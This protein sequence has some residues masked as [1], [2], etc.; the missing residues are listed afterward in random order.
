MKNQRLKILSFS[1]IAIF[2]VVIIK[3][4]YYQ[5]IAG[6]SLK[7]KNMA[8][9]YKIQ[10][11]S[12]NRGN[13][14]D[15]SNFPLATNNNWYQLSIYKPNLK[16][17]LIDVLN[18][19]DTK[20]TDFI[21]NNQNVIDIFS[22]NENQLWYTFPTQF[23]KEEKDALDID[24][25]SFETVQDRFYPEGN[26]GKTVIKGLENYYDKQL[27]GK[28]GFILAPKDAIGN[29]L[30]TQKTWQINSKNGIDLKTSLKRNIQYYT[31]QI[32]KKGL[33]QFS[34]D[35]GS[36]IIMDS[37]T[38]GI[39]AMST[40]EASPSGKNI[41][42]SDLFE[43]GS[44]FKPLVMSMA[45]DS[46]S[47]KPDYICPKCAGPL[48]IGE[49][50]ITN[51]D[52]K[53]HPNT[54]LKDII[55]NSDNVGMSN[56][57]EQLGQKKFQEYFEKLGLTQKTGIDLQGEAKPLI[58][59][60]YSKID[61]ATAAFGQGIAIS[62]IEFL[63]AFNTIANNG[64]MLQPWVNKHKTR[65]PQNIFKESTI[66][67]IKNIMK[68]AVETGPLNKLRPSGMEICAKSGTAQIA[69]G[70]KYNENS[71]IASY[72]GFSPCFNPRFTMIVT[73]NNP[74]SSEWGSQTAA[75]IWYEIA[76]KLYNLL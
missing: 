13:I 55:K 54:D 20:K 6:F 58:K 1:I 61:L 40:I 42:I 65:L 75:P 45:L 76:E 28:T 7:E 72:V 52:E 60:R 33:E 11:I 32:L 16:E 57:I 68:Y 69:V 2:F 37:S 63:Q 51:W 5:A 24:G 64:I 19:I 4:F 66:T 21:I 47:I 27:S 10:K 53:F 48:T 56:I 18:L 74:K 46:N 41:S 29:T 36:A 67:E 26:L 14:Y 17:S 12:P 71:T 59:N 9:M 70:G 49:Y 22:K 8:Q 50:T 31:E 15:S 43:P 62:Q 73:Y 38:G 3:L 39:I 44:I 25:V 35:S 23:T 30:L 34:A